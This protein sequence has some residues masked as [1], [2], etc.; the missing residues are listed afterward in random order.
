MLIGTDSWDVEIQLENT[1]FQ[2]YIHA[3]IEGDQKGLKTAYIIYGWSPQAEQA[4]YLSILDTAPDTFEN[5]CKCVIA[6]GNQA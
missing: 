1:K 4:T 6:L 5:C 2:N 3:Y